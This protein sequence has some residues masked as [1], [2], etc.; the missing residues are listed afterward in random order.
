[1]KLSLRINSNNQQVLLGIPSLNT[2]YLF[3]KKKISKH[4][5]VVRYGWIVEWINNGNKAIV[6]N[7]DYE[8]DGIQN[9]AS[10]F[11]YYDTYDGH[12]LN[13]S[14][15]P[16]SRFPNMDQYS[17]DF[18]KKY[19]VFLTSTT[20]VLYAI[21]AIR[22]SLL[23]IP[24]SQPGFYSVTYVSAENFGKKTSDVF[25]SIKC[26][27]MSTCIT[28]PQCTNES[29]CPFEFA[30]VNTELNDIEQYTGYPETP[31]IDVFGDILLPN[32]QLNAKFETNLQFLKKPYG[33]LEEII[34][35][36]NS[37]ELTFN[38]GPEIRQMNNYV[39]ELNFSKIFNYS[40]GILIPESQQLISL[41][42]TKI[43][44]ITEDLIDPDLTIF[45]G[46]WFPTFTFDSDR[47]S[48]DI[49]ETS[50][51]H[52]TE[53]SV[54]ISETSFFIRNKQKPIARSS[55]IIFETVLFM[56]MCLDLLCMI[57]LLIKLWFK[58]IYWRE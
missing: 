19:L 56:C 44:N 6:A 17:R 18:S 25:L 41:Q 51:I 2:V 22:D 39:Q 38:C 32:Y 1:M 12:Y 40:S 48:V 58:P 47:L 46:L 28:C 15:I 8:Y 14:T 35:L 4:L 10:F 23:I 16:F 31:E 57:F 21:N 42:L 54:K 43:I 50:S 37:Q 30:S 49:D 52:H 13:N 24:E 9:S 5:T 27:S 26:C 55:E 7:V 34:H 3:V 36:L 45:S 29:Y 20:S 33:Q 11:E 53:V